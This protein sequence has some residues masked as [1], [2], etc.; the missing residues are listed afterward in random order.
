MVKDLFGKTRIKLGLHIHTTRSDGKYAPEVTAQI[1]KEAGYDAI[2][3][4]DHWVYGEADEICGLP[5]LSGAEYNIGFVDCNEGVYHILSLMCEREPSVN[6]DFSA[7]QIIDA[8]AEAGGISVLA[9]PAWSLNTPEMIKELRGFDAT[10]IYNAVSDINFSRRGDS[11]LIVDM[12]GMQ[13]YF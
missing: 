11:T 10:E 5:I 7:Q 1:Y 4:T 6:K 9:H 3:L 2:A 13:G 12:L 8:I